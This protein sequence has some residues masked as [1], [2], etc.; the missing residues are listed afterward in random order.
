MISAAGSL[1]ASRHG[2]STGHRLEEAEYRGGFYNNEI[3]AAMSYESDEHKTEDE[4]SI[5]GK[6]IRL[7]E[8][9]CG[10]AG[11]VKALFALRHT[12]KNHLSPKMP[13]P[14]HHIQ[15]QNHLLPPDHWLRIR[16]H[17]HACRGR[18]LRGYPRRLPATAGQ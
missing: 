12:S 10:Y 5:S 8:V 2:G 9:L 15:H 13:T 18:T 11:K 6:T 16:T 1:S 3:I 14:Y 4:F 7:K 17:R